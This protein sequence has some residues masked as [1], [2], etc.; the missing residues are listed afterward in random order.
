MSRFSFSM[1]KKGNYCANKNEKTHMI[2]AGDQRFKQ[3]IYCRTTET[4]VTVCFSSE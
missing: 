3:I 2:A 1:F 4:A